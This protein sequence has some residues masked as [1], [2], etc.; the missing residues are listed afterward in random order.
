MEGFDYDNEDPKD[1]STLTDAE[2]IK[3]HKDLLE[4][5]FNC[6]ITGLSFTEIDD[7]LVY[8]CEESR[9]KWPY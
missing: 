2:L 9:T 5:E 3:L 8:R 7:E 1:V 4:S 6:P